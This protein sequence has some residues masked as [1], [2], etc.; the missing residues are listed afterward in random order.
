[1]KNIII[2]KNSR[3]KTDAKPK[4]LTTYRMHNL[5]I[6]ENKIYSIPLSLGEID[7]S[8]NEHKNNS[9]I[10]IYDTQ[11]EACRAL[12]N[13]PYTLGYLRMDLTSNC[14]IRCIMCQTHNLNSDNI[15]FDFD[16][17]KAQTKGKL[18][19]WS[20]I[21]IGNLAEPTIHPRFG[22]FLEYIRS[23]SDALIIIVTNGILLGKYASLINKLKNISVQ[24][25]IDSLNKDI[26]EKIRKGSKFDKVMRAVK[27]LD[28]S[29]TQVKLTFTLM[30][31]NVKEYDSV[32][33]FCKQNNYGYDF[34]PM[35]LR[36]DQGKSLSY[37]LIW[38]S[39]WFHKKE[40]KEW[41]EKFYGKNYGE[42]AKDNIAIKSDEWNPSE[43]DCNAHEYD[44]LIDASGNASLCGM[45]QLPNLNKKSLDL[46]WNSEEAVDFRE[47]INTDRSPCKACGYRKFCLSPSITELK[48]HIDG[49]IFSMLSKE[50]KKKISLNNSFSD[51][52][53]LRFFL[54]D[55]IDSIAVYLK[56]SSKKAIVFSDFQK[57]LPPL[58]LED[59]IFQN[60]DII[61]LDASCIVKSIN[62]I[63]KN[64]EL[65]EANINAYNIVSYHH[66][67]LGVP[68]SLGVLDLTVREARELKGIIRCNSLQVLKEK[69]AGK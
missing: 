69:I 4:L 55:I 13:K 37:N 53:R 44:L 43:F 15:Y 19:A 12:E 50:T 51:E 2:I 35:H 66:F 14:N 48:N 28:T 62:E 58:E 27:M 25:S 46:I 65:I 30:Y 60:S 54:D 5:V 18:D 29:V 33:E 59:I 57:I 45:Q 22:D 9:H 56:T 63:Y 32:V 38:E 34:Y 40:M 3:K 11:K 8:K 31:S 16:V 41:I 24:I 47:K 6:Y 49:A 52:E 17:F 67:Y 21:Q 39:L 1:M 7:F 20:T 42:V 61:E 10:S 64:L 68:I 23:E 26:H 36:R